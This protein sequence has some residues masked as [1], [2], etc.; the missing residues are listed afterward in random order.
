M[1][2]LLVC[3]T[4]V[5]FLF[6]CDDRREWAPDLPGCQVIATA[7]SQAKRV[8]GLSFIRLKDG[9]LYGSFSY[10]IGGQ[11][12]D[13]GTVQQRIVRSTD[14]GQSF[15]L[16]P[17]LS[18]V[19]L[20]DLNASHYEQANGKLVMIH[21]S[22]TDFSIQESAVVQ[23]SSADNGKTYGGHT[24]LGGANGT[25]Q[26]WIAAPGRIFKLNDGLL[27]YPVARRGLLEQHVR[28]ALL[29]LSTDDGSSW[30][31]AKTP[32]G[33]TL[34]IRSGSA[35][36]YA[37]EPGLYQAGNGD[38]YYYFRSRDGFVRAAN[39][40]RTGNSFSFDSLVNLLPAPASL[41]EIK[42]IPSIKKYIAVHN[43]FADVVDENSNGRKN[44]VY[45]LSDSGLP[46]TFKKMPNPIKAWADDA[47][48]VIQPFVFA[49]EQIKGAIVAFTVF[50]DNG[51][52]KLRST[53]YT[54]FLSDSMLLSNSKW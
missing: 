22:Q 12:G 40:K 28:E 43:D 20:G 16:G 42:Y 38:L 26:R 1:R 52:G 51:K 15:Q 5:V 2:S 7:N 47:N 14:N 9:R 6:S 46:G 25:G 18:F 8:D 49:D 45:S 48:Y 3:V 4:T 37:T 34:I 30:S 44:L 36:N 24:Y 32:A 13:N 53:Q 41:S 33:D 27:L 31:F 19:D 54:R 50:Y 21:L 29:L 23:R 35:A 11:G 39:L 17:T 10:W